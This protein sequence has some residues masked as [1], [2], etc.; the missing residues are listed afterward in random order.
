MRFVVKFYK[1]I[2]IPDCIASDDTTIGEYDISKDME[3][4]NCSLIKVLSAITAVDVPP[5]IRTEYLPYRSPE[6]YRYTN[7]LDIV[8]E[9][10]SNLSMADTRHKST[11]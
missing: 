7:L 3:E 1:T 11:I 4:L 2:R 10:F 5:K 6:R 9:G 8:V